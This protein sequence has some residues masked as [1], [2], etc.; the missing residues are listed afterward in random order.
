[1]HSGDSKQCMMYDVWCMMYGIMNNIQW[2]DTKKSDSIA[3]QPV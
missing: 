1:M 2:N 3:K